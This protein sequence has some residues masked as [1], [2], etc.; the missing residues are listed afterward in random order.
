MTAVDERRIEDCEK[1]V[2]VCFNAKTN[3]NVSK[4]TL[5][6][7]VIRSSYL[8]HFLAVL[9]YAFTHSENLKWENRR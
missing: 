6:P 8:I 5:F 9:H 7:A 3:E 4:D 1:E 2:T